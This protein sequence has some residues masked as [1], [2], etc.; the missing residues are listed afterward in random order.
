[1]DDLFL[2]PKD[3]GLL[4]S[5]FFYAFALIQIPMGAAIDV[6]GV[7]RLT[8]TLSL[9]GIAGAVC[10]AFANSLLVG[11]IGRALQGVGMA[12]ALM[13][14]Y[15]FISN[16]FPPNAFATMSGFVLS[17]GTLGNMLA[18]APLA[19]AVKSMG[20]R[21]A[22]LLIA[23]FHFLIGLLVYLVVKDKPVQNGG[24]SDQFSKR[25]ELLRNLIDG[26][27]RVLRLPSFWLIALAAFVRYG[28]YIS[29][30][31]LWAGPYLE[32]VYKIPLVDRGKI[33]MLFPAGFLLG[34]PI[35]GF[36]SDRVFKNR[37]GVALVG[38]S[39]YTI[40]VFPLTGF[41]VPLSLKMI[42]VVFFVLG[43]LHS[44]NLLMYANIKGLVP[45]SFSGTA[46]SA[47]NFFYISGAG[48]FQLL[49]GVLIDKSLLHQ[50]KLPSEVF[51][52]PFGLCF[53]ASAIG[54]MGYLFVK[55]VRR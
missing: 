39:F 52:L 10:F 55:E 6:F 9:V 26:I 25:I 41:L 36:L 48:F 50:G 21:K 40:C 13:V 35:F 49:M 7:R 30:A 54:T 51:S 43:F 45:D 42:A 20:W 11:I 47:V 2:T 34:G 28:S 38:L 29:I 44:S 4:S 17:I 31:G 12:C 22:F 46:M 5:T 32:Y 8:L 19:L 24:K 18:T 16:W 1:M 53:A 3:L 27:L 14:T 15:K 33:L 23:L 37:K